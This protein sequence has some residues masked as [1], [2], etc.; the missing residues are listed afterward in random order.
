VTPG[1]DSAA[2]SLSERDRSGEV[3]TDLREWHGVGPGAPGLS[4]MNGSLVESV[5]QRSPGAGYRRPIRS[6]SRL[7][8]MRRRGRRDGEAQREHRLGH[9]VAATCTPHARTL[10]GSVWVDEAISEWRSIA[11]SMA[12]DASRRNDRR[13]PRPIGRSA[14]AHLSD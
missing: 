8:S 9:F 12:F 14:V 6:C 2:H 5:I 1:W 3:S 4:Q 10:L 7:H 13:V 11:S